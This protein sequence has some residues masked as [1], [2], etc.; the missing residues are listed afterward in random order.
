M[1][2]KTTSLKKKGI[3]IL[4]LLVGVFLFIHFLSGVNSEELLNY[5]AHVNIKVLIVAVVLGVV[6]YISRAV[7]WTLVL[8]S[9][10]YKVS[11]L[12]SLTAVNWG[13]LYN[14]LIPRS[15]EALRVVDLNRS[16]DIP[17]SAGFG[18]I[19]AERLFDLICMCLVLCI[20]LVLKWGD[21][22][23]LLTPLIQRFDMQTVLMSALIVIGFVGLGILV[24]KKIKGRMT[25]FIRGLREGFMAV[26]KVKQKGLFLF[27]TVLIWACYYIIT[28]LFVF[29]FE[30]TQHL[31]MGDASLVM[32]MGMLGL[33]A[34][35]NA[36][37][38]TYHYMVKIALVYL[39]VPDG[40]AIAFATILH[41][42]QT[43]IP[44]VL[45]VP[46][47]VWNKLIAKTV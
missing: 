29:A 23:L 6:A 9:A 24:F 10:G 28:Y 40:M 33:L 38:G 16:T 14:V 13:Y 43:L 7:R 41:M 39:V 37:I 3:T 18:T 25:E 11:F 36:G 15:G 31:T 20:T 32:S 1:F 46:L 45:V 5:I 8:K 34:P 42:S 44:F 30:E 26:I 17:L 22:L 27:H 2:Q 12:D 47:M 4:F 35:T 19:L 21:L